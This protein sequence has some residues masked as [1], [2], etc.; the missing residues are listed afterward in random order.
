MTRRIYLDHWVWIKLA[1][2]AQGKPDAAAWTDC[3][4]VA[5]AATKSGAVSLPL[6]SIH[7]M[8]LHAGATPGQRNAIG[9]LM[10]ELSKGH[11]MIAMGDAVLQMEVDLALKAKTGRPYDPR[12]VQVFGTGVGHALGQPGYKL[13]IVDGDGKRPTDIPAELLRLE[14]ELQQVAEMYLL[15]GPAE[16]EHVPGYNP[17]A[18]TQFDRA[19][20]RAEEDFAAALSDMPKE[21][22]ADM[23]MARIWVQDVLPAL[24]GAMQRAALP[25]SSVQLNSKAALTEWLRDIPTAWT[26]TELRRLRHANPQQAWKAQDHGDLRFLTVALNYCDAVMPDKAWARLARQADLPD[27]KGCRLL[28]KPTELLVELAN[29]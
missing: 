1:R 5:R 14:L 9:R 17:R 21:K 2:A 13:H 7:Y 18:H 8:E 12:R 24:L 6:S 19:F 29:S 4:V 16:G 26:L 3:L 28:T 27:A 10:M 11:T 20:A 23:L 15:S 22:Y 25:M